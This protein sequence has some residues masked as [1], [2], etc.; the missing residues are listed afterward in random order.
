MG[1]SIREAGFYKIVFQLVTAFAALGGVP[2][3]QMYTRK[4]PGRTVSVAAQTAARAVAQ[5]FGTQLRTVEKCLRQPALTA[6][7]TARQGF[8]KPAALL[9]QLPVGFRKEKFP[10]VFPPALP[11]TQK[12][13]F[14]LGQRRHAVFDIGI[15]QEFFK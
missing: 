14:K 11:Q 3:R 15:G 5:A 12:R 2:D 4:V 9:R 13:Q 10:Q 1:S 8:F 6:A 7:G